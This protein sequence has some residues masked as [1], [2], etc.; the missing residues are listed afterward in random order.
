MKKILNVLFLTLLFSCT[1]E[2]TSSNPEDD[3]FDRQ[4]MLVNLT[5]NIILPSFYDF[6][7]EV[8]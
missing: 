4:A 6:S 8:V 2:D 7:Q 5:D 1:S 3:D